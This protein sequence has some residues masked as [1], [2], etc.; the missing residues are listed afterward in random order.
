M[1]VPVFTGIYVQ[2]INLMVSLYSNLNYIKVR[3][4]YLEIVKRAPSLSSTII[5]WKLVLSVGFQHNSMLSVVDYLL[6]LP[7]S[8]PALF[9]ACG[10][11]LLG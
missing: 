11:L 10:A 1:H 9:S 5:F 8:R 2:G 6:S 7:C 3:C 4:A